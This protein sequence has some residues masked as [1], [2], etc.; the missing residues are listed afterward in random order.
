[1]TLTDAFGNNV[2]EWSITGTLVTNGQLSPMPGDVYHSAGR[3]HQLK[4]FSA[5]FPS[6]A[7]DSWFA[8]KTLAIKAPPYLHWSS[9]CLLLFSYLCSWLIKG[10]LLSGEFLLINVSDFFL[11]FFFFYFWLLMK[12]PLKA[13][14]GSTSIKTNNLSVSLFCKS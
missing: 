10:R 1:M 8:L 3:A 9:F 5:G 4:Q 6:R 11:F 7:S 12:C 2:L 13:A 14:S